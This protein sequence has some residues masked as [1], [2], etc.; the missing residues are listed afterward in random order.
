MPHQEQEL[1]F[2]TEHP[3]ALLL[4]EMGTGKTPVMLTYADNSL[5]RGGKVLWITTK[6]LGEQLLHEA[7]NWLTAD[8]SPVQIDK[9]TP[10]DNL[11]YLTHQLVKERMPRLTDLGPWD[12]VIVDEAALVLRALG[13]DPDAAHGSAIASVISSAKR[14]VCATGTPMDTAHGLDL[15]GLAEAAALPGLPTRQEYLGHVQMGT[16]GNGHGGTRSYPL[17]V[18]RE[19]FRSLAAAIKA[20]SIRHTAEDLQHE[21]PDVQVIHHR[22]PLTREAA[23]EYESSRYARSPLHAHQIKQQSSRDVLPMIGA[24]ID[25]ITNLD[26]EDRVIAFS[27]QR[28]LVDGLTEWLDT[29]S[30]QFALITGKESA[31]KRAEAMRRL[32]DGRALVLVMTGAGEVGVN[33]QTANTMITLARTYSPAREWQRIARM[34]RVGTQHPSL[35]HH[36]ITPDVQHEDRKEHVLSAKEKQVALLWI[37][38]SDSPACPHGEL[39][40]REGMSKKGFAWAGWFCPKKKCEVIW[41]GGK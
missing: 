37:L 13:K 41:E 17:G 32:D 10:K 2:L 29:L 23:E 5:L 33:G 19:G 18:D 38:L 39:Q 15:F 31:K 12:L 8:V 28:D 35:T 40:H 9:A 25:I 27:D 1:E 14:S 16:A 24:A 3:R 22:V 20:S 26:P 7:A 30:I 4:S 21:L 36:I 6:S 34:R 11:V